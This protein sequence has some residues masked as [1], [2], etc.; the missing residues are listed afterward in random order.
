MFVIFLSRN[1]SFENLKYLTVDQSIIDTAHLIETV[2][3]D[4]ETDAK[5]ILWGSGFGASLATWT[6]QKFPHLVDG[7]WSSS[8]VYERSITTIGT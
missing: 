5:V 4:L 8:G 6:R 7:V 1:A 3:R 2:K